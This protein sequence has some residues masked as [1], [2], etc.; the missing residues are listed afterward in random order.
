M[1]DVLNSPDV[2]AAV[3]LE[4]GKDALRA[5]LANLLTSTK[6]WETMNEKERKVCVQSI[7]SQVESELELS[8]RLNEIG[9]TDC[10]INW[11]DVDPN[12]QTGLE[13]QALV[14]AL[15]GLVSKSGALVMVMTCEDEF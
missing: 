5:Q 11:R 12:D 8:R 10:A 9:C 2:Q 1:I 15:G 3:R 6:T 13:A 4:K 14:K 7:V